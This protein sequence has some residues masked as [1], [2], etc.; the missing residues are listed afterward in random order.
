[1]AT[2]Y[3]SR[4]FLIYS[5]YDAPLNFS[6]LHEKV[7]YQDPKI[8]VIHPFHVNKKNIFNENKSLHLDASSPLEIRV[9]SGTN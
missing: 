2:S 3:P 7:G 9:V 8:G 1:M 4:F 6:D 5:G